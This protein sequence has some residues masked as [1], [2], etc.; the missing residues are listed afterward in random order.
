VNKIDRRPEMLSII[1]KKGSN[2][3]NNNNEVADYIKDYLGLNRPNLNIFIQSAKDYAVQ[4]CMDNIA[5]L[6]Y[7]LDNK[8]ISG[9]P[10]TMSE[11]YEQAIHAEKAFTAGVQWAFQHM[12]SGNNENSK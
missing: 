9:K 12:K 8:L 10:Y 4:S 2:H 11:L 6:N 1:S 3:K 5:S 7:G